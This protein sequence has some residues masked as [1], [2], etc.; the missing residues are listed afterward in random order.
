[1]SLITESVLLG[2]VQNEMRKSATFSTNV[3]DKARQIINE[4]HAPAISGIDKYDIFLSHS[5]DYAKKVA[6]LK[7]LLNDMGYK[8]YVDWIED[9]LINRKNVNKTTA[10]KLQERMKEST[11][12]VY[13]FSENSSQS[14]WMPWEL[15][16]FDG[17]K[18]MVAVLPISTRQS[19]SFQGT[20]Y[21]G[22]Y[23]YID[24]STTKNSTTEHL[25]VNETTLKYVLFE[26]WLR[27]KVQPYERK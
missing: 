12:L 9:P 2:R 14:K 8:V 11:S 24:I 18:G 17:I 25:W 19:S 13:A 6:G 22:I 3:E 16:Y 27:K 26:E 7:L 1:M 5:S 15:G 10:Q 23:P 21:L 4:T 20:E